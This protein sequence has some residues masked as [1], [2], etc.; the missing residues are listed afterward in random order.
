LIK[1]IYLLQVMRRVEDGKLGRRLSFLCVEHQPSLEV[2][3]TGMKKISAPYLSGS[4][5]RPREGLVS[6]KDSIRS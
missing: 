1:E 4:E 6:E 3:H 5:A 2:V